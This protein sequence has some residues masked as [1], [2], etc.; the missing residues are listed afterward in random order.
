MQP[1]PKERAHIDRVLSERYGPNSVLPSAAAAAQ[2]AAL[3]A[4][5]HATEDPAQRLH[6]EIEVLVYN[7]QGLPP[8]DR[9]DG[10]APST[11]VHYQLLN[12]QVGLT[13]LA[14]LT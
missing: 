12:F 4:E 11:Y 1:S 8:R 6:N 14:S 7:A 3:S 5:A 13:I 10:Q 9:T 2:P